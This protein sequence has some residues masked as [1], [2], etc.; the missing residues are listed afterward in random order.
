MKTILSILSLAFVL[1]SC[2][3]IIEIELDTIEPKLVIEGCINDLND[4]FT[5]ILSKTGDYFEPG[6]YPAVSGAM[7]SVTDE[8]GIETEFEESEPGLYISESLEVFENRSYTLQVQSEGEDY[9]A[10]G[11]IPQKVYIDSL[12]FDIPPLLY[13]FEEGYMVTCYLQDPGAFRNYYRLKAYKKGEPVSSEESKYIFN[14][15]FMNGNMIFMPWE[16]EAFFPLD[17]VVVELHTLDKSTY[18]YYLTLNSL[19]G[20][21]FGAANPANPKTNLSNDALGYFGAYTVS[22]DTIVIM[23]N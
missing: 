3:D 5:I 14:D 9:M 22:R 21:L 12:S 13:E 17:T 1:V 16:N 2:E 6:I 7:V 10:E 23:P 18:D 20:G 11:T 4:P 8:Y 15:D 19:A